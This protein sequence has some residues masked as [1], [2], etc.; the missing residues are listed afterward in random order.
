MTLAPP[1]AAAPTCS[2]SRAKSAERID[3]AS[4]IKS[5]SQN[6]GDCRNDVVEILSRSRVVRRVASRLAP[7]LLP[8]KSIQNPAAY[9]FNEAVYEAT[10]TMSSRLR[11]DTTGFIR[12]AAA[13]LRAP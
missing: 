13:P 1:S 6:Q 8:A 9:G 4:S 11:F 12:F 10:A 7:A 2:P 3:G 5:D